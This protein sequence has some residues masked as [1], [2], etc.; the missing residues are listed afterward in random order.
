MLTYRAKADGPAV[1]IPPAIE[2]AGGQAIERYA[3]A[4]E[5][6]RA[7]QLEAAQVAAATAAAAPE[8]TE[9]PVPT[10]STSRARA[11]SASTPHEE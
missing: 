6:D 8:S 9:S 3:A 4:S 5:S 2:A 1:Q 10:P 11:R 7:Q